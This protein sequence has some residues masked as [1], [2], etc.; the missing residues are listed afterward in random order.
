MVPFS[1]LYISVLCETTVMLFY[2]L[3]CLTILCQMGKTLQM[4][5]WKITSIFSNFFFPTLI[6]A[7]GYD[8]LGD[9]CVISLH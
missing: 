1:K 9:A 3:D 7:H 8:N 2:T 6:V 4:E 5:M